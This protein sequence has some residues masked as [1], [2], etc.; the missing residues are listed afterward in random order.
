MV[1]FVLFLTI[2]LCDDTHLS[3]VSE[4]WKIHFGYERNPGN[5]SGV[6]NLP[7]GTICFLGGECKFSLVDT[8]ST[9]E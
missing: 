2:A 5:P 8:L 4:D 1:L 3:V 9:K 7:G 6:L